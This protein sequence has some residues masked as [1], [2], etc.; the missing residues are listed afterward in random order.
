MRKFYFTNIVALFSNKIKDTLKNLQVLVLF[1]IF[2]IIGL[3]MTTA[4]DV[5][6]EAGGTMFFVAVFATIHCIFAPLAATASMIAEEKE[7]NTL[8]ILIMSNVTMPEYLIATGGFV[9]F[10]T[11][12][13]GSAFLFM[14][15]AIMENG[16]A[17]MLNLSLGCLV[18]V[19]LGMCLGLQAKNASA[20]NAMAV[21][22]GM[23]F[24]FL[25]MLASFDETIASISR[26]TYGQQISNFIGNLQADASGLLIVAV[27]LV[28]LLGLGIFLYRQVRTEE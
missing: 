24:A 16:L 3:V 27:N 25:P 1:I 2:P 17:F 21:P 8:R 14:E 6:E 7:K 9:L 23:V 12:L 13:T 15:P 19:S 18:S 26:F 5:P 11:L 20:A 28:I 22:V 4:V 10:L